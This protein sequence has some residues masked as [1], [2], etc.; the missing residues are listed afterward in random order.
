MA[1][2]RLAFLAKDNFLIQYEYVISRHTREQHWQLAAIDYGFA[3][4]E[5]TRR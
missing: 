3:N 1:L 2:A 4:K 5:K